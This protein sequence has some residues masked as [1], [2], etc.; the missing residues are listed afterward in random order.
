MVLAGY[1]EYTG[2]QIIYDPWPVNSGAT[3]TLSKS[4][5]EYLYAASD[6]RAV[7]VR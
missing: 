5:V 4:R 3:V 6:Y 7:V 1:N 2:E